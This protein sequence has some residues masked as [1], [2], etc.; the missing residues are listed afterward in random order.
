MESAEAEEKPS[1][2]KPFQVERQV[3]EQAVK[4]KIIRKSWNE[5]KKMWAIAGPAILVSVSQFSI[6]F[7]TVAS[8]GHLGAL[9]LAAVTITTNVI[10]G[11]VFGIMLGMGSALE[12]L[13]GQAVGAGQHNMLGIYL[14]RSWIITGV[15]ALCLTPFYLLASPILK[16]LRQD[17]DISELAGKYCRM[18]VP[19]FF[20]YAMNFP[21]QKFLQSQRKVWVM[22]I[23][24][25]VALAIHVLLNWALV[26]KLHL[27]LLGAAMAGNISWWLQV[28]AMIIY[29]VSGFFP[30]SWTGLSLLAFKSLWG[31]VKLS[32]ASAVMLCLELWYFTA[33]I[34]MVGYLKNPTLAVDAISICMNLQLWTSMVTLGFNAA[35]SVRVSN[36][37]GAGRP[38]A[39]KFSIVVAVLTSLM[40]GI[41]FTAVILAAKHD[42]PK[43][44]TDKPLV[45][46]ETS[47]LGYFLAATIFLNSI[48]PVLHGV[49]VGAG[50]QASVGLIN[51]ACY[52]IFGIPAG[53]L[54]GFKF[55]LGVEGIWS[56][57]L[58]G[59]VLQ[60]TI[61]LLIM[62]RSSWRKEAVQ[63]EERLRTWGGSTETTEASLESSAAG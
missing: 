48:L 34:L 5:S 33:I 25:V 30:E 42:F 49:A 17:K 37:L 62:L 41:I 1:E 39:A 13:C 56:G 53:A 51:I 15:T 28:I 44:F 8:V 22:T 4:Q 6:G 54:L 10:E 47:K 60:T 23:I 36:E 31:F 18:V 29:V 21:I 3:G 32:L 50:W 45:I 24:S 57:M 12:T 59:T 52:Y 61:L 19:Q 16:L 14:Q 63:A 7:V 43:L 27:G 11:F 26:T 46:K 38:K 40:V 58:V 55:K 2:V 35:V 9:E 20:A